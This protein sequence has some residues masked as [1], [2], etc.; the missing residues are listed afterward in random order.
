MLN[1]VDKVG[2]FLFQGASILVLLSFVGLLGVVGLAV[3]F[4]KLRE[5]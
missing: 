2:M 1:L 3:F 4:E 5:Y